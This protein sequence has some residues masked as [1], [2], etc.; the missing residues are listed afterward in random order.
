[1]I[2]VE[3]RLEQ[4]ILSLLLIEAVYSVRRLVNTTRFYRDSERSYA[5]LTHHVTVTVHQTRPNP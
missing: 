1:M 5:S 3:S 2:N 4:L